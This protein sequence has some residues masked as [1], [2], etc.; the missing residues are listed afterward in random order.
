MLAKMS[1]VSHPKAPEP[2]RSGLDKPK[3]SAFTR[4]AQKVAHWTGQPATFIVAVG[5]IV[6]WAVTG[7]FVGF[8]DTWQLIINTST[9]I[10]TFLMVFVIQ[11]S[12]NRDTTALHIKLDE[13]IS[14]LEGPREKLMDL[15]ELDEEELERIRAEFEQRACRSRAAKDEGSAA[16]GGDTAGKDATEK[17]VVRKSP[18]RRKVAAK[19]AGAARIPG[20]QA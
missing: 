10:I 13:L 14:R 16:A 5:I 7:P 17:E 8:N 18:G 6:L 3:R 20:R 9:T 4:F 2:T 1:A 15:E 19:P 12:Q 11:N